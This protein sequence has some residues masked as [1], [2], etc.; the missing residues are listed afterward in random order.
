MVQSAVLGFPRIGPNRELKKATEGYWNG[1]I[2]V[3]ELF[4]V[5]KDLRTQN[6]KL[7]KEAG[8]DI[9]PSNDFSFY[10]QVLD[11]SLLFN[12]IP[13]RYTKYDL[14]PIDTLFAMGRGLQRK[15]TATEKAVDVTALEMVK[16]FDSNYHYV[17]P[18]FSKTTQFKLNGQKPVD[19]YLEAKGLG[20]QTRPVLL[21]PV[22]Y[23]FLGKADKDSL[24]LEPLSLLEQL[25][26]LYAEILSKLA[27]AGA[28]DVQIDEPVLVLDLPANAQA[29]IKKAYA[30]FGEQSNLP[31]ITLATYFGTVVP[32]LD[33]I[34][35]LPVA[36]LHVDFVRAPEQFDDVIAAIG[37]K[38]TLSVGIVDGR[39]IWKN[40]F[41]KSSAVV[42]KA[43]EKLGADRVVVAT[44][45]SLLHT[46]VDLNNETKL[47]AEIKG[48][49]SFATQKLDEVV[50]ITKHVSGGNVTAALE[51]NA[52]SVESRGKS[53]L[54]HNSAVK[55]RVASIDEKM[56]TRA[57]PFEQRLPEQQKVFNLP[58]FP[59]TTIGSFPQTKDI[60][61]NRNKFNKGTISAEEY[62]KFINS[63]IEKVIRFQEEIG[64][65]VL[66]HGEPERNDMVQYFGEQIN[67]YAFTVNG[68]VQSYGS[69]YVR[70]PIIVGDLSRPKAMS[71]KES[72]YAQSITSKPV[73]GMLT[74]PITCLRWSFPRDDVDQKTQAMQLALALRDEVNDLEAAGIN[75]I[76][77]DEP[78]LREGLPLREG[79]ERSAYYTWAAE[80]FRVAT[81]G[82]ANKTQ[83]HS[84]FCYSDLDPN[85]I[86]A[87]DADVVSI[88]F[89]KKDDANY[90]AEFKNY[91][92]H[93]GLGLFDI[94]S[95]RVPSKDE[96]IA[97]ISTVLKTY[98]ADKFWVN[99]DCGLKTRGWEETRLSLTHMVE[100]AKYFREQYKN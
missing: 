66:V 48:F 28:T 86:K 46:P 55:T 56:S 54:I 2:T 50:V 61:I 70:P 88:E 79:A 26:P 42:N 18:T 51:A 96:F 84:H 32:N 49:F 4:K 92:N 35:G 77:V 45:S 85:H 80:A 38:Q 91:P 75:V 27:A 36:A 82:V 24:D 90:I 17:R 29:A 64:L 81:S 99:P 16:W 60:R 47:D 53:K 68:W 30:Y 6:W 23:L 34:K 87:L 58:L 59:T 5:G 98:P 19:E 13:D 83:I 12:V 9:I 93:I 97:K 44:S 25:L 57:V 37:A 63:E 40:D 73:K 3:D 67:G 100:A 14:S 76:Q 22:S 65:D 74:G 7:Q 89:S 11:L 94:H 52:T 8:V 31:K 41:K 1:K 21:G 72:V 15:A 62:E 95:P 33:A 43:I 71:V 10:D 78:A 69:R 20:I 39:N